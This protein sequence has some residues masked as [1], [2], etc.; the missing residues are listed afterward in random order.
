MMK[1]S[2][3][4]K[5]GGSGLRKALALVL[6]AATLLPFLLSGAASL[7][8]EAAENEH[9]VYCGEEAVTSVSLPQDGKCT[10]FVAERDGAAYA[11]QLSVGGGEGQQWVTVSGRKQSTLTLSYAMVASLLDSRGV[12]RVRSVIQ[13]GEISSVSRPVTVRV[14]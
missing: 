7:T 13:T 6:C 8:A 4:K 9:A 14:D 3:R 11:W 5:T 10:L 12:T 2:Q 1:R